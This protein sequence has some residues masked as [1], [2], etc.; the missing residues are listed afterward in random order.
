MPALTFVIIQ[1]VNEFETFFLKKVNLFFESP[2]LFV[3]NNLL[4]KLLCYNSIFISLV[5][6]C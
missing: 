1:L 2:Y 4:K 5:F 3:K 6:T